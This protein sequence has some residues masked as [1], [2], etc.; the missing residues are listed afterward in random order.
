MPCFFVV[1]ICH[2][3][4]GQRKP[5]PSGCQRANLVEIRAHVLRR[6]QKVP[7]HRRCGRTSLAPLVCCGCAGWGAMGADMRARWTRHRLARHFGR[8]V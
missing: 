6:L 1:Y 8:V 5:T 2:L 7:C 4:G 3:E